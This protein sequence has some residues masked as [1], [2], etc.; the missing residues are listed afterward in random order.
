MRLL[1]G[2]QEVVLV[3]GLLGQSPFGGVS[4]QNIRQNLK[5]WMKNQHLALWRSPFSTQRQTR[6][7]ICGPNLATGA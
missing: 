4:R 6:E 3:S 2:S 7:L 5:R 1:T